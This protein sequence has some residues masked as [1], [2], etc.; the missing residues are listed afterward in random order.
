M[1][2]SSMNVRDVVTQRAHTR[3]ASLHGGRRSLA[4]EVERISRQAQHTVKGRGG[5]PVV[6]W[7][8]SASQS[9]WL[10]VVSP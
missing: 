7:L 2:S 1:H 6:G 3:D 4:V 5:L 8:R 10:V 9:G